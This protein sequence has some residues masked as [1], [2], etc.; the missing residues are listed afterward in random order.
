MWL[1]KEINASKQANCKVHFD[2]KI[3][4]NPKKR[5]KQLSSLQK[6]E[7][8]HVF[9][10]EEFTQDS[11]F[12]KTLMHMRSAETLGK[13]V[14]YKLGYS[15]FTFELWILLHKKLLLTSLNHRKEYL[16]EINNTFHTKFKSL[17]DFKEEHNFHKILSTLTLDDVMHALIHGEK[18]IQEQYAVGHTP[19]EHAK[20]LYFQEN[21]S[22]SIHEYI[23]KI[24]D[25]IGFHYKLS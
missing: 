2:I 16:R 23:R 19:K 1:E 9:D 12:K 14:K 25:D 20:Y 4:K 22:L 5:V 8:L 21:P 24:F 6:I 7:I 11:S 13:Q 3:E 17:S 18:I 15:N 10:F